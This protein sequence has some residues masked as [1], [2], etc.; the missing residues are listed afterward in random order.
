MLAIDRR[1]TI[2]DIVQ[3]QRSVKVYD[4]SQQFDVTEET[5]RRDLE[6]LERDGHV[7]RTYGGAVISESTNTDLSVNVRETTN[8]EGKKKIAMKI[9][10]YIQDGDTIMMDSSTTALYV[11]KNI[12]NK[13]NITIITNSLKIPNEVANHKNCEV[14]LTGGTLKTS[15][16]SFV[17]HW[18]EAAI[19]K[20]YVNKVI[21]SCKGIDSRLG[22]SEPNEMEAEI[23]KKMISSSDVSIL[24]A[25]NTKFNK[26]SFIK[27][28]ELRNIDIL[29]TDEKLDAHWEELLQEMKIELVYA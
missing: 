9:A 22:I 7:K 23:K 29:I 28:V 12:S 27:S 20:Y 2:L 15:S 3:K 24:V 18:A 11:I 16:L 10:E 13:K 1:Q 19:E 8:I 21:M 5:I 17:G 6:K 25:D 26:K 4:L 14:I